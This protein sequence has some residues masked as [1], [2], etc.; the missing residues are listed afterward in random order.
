MA[1]SDRKTVPYKFD[2]FRELTE[3]F[4]RR[5]GVALVFSAEGGDI[6]KV[7]Y[8]ELAD[9]IWKRTA[10]LDGKGPGTDV[11]I[12]APT[13]DSIVEIFAEVVACRCIIM[14]DPMMPADALNEA[15]AA[16]DRFICDVTEWR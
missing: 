1:T 2:S 11:V 10:E 13:V 4:G 15:A 14:A 5:E 12:A 9:R 8:K 6:C 3:D 7:S 16:A